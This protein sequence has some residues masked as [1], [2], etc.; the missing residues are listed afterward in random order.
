MKP[1]RIFINS[2]EVHDVVKQMREPDCKWAKVM[3]ITTEIAGGKV[4]HIE[5]RRHEMEDREPNLV[6]RCDGSFR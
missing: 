3:V 4:Y 6:W 5:T 1:P 2:T